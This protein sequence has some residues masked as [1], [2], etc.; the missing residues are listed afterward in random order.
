MDEADRCDEL[1]FVRDG[2]VI[3]QGT[4]A[5]LRATAGTDNLEA[6][7]LVLSGLDPEGRPL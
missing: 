7:F 4:G 6:A 1:V 3:G 2:K 5:Q